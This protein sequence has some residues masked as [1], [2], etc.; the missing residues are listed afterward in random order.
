MSAYNI[1]EIS[2]LMQHIMPTIGSRKA[3][4]MANYR[5]LYNFAKECVIFYSTYNNL[6][7]SYYITLK[8]IPDFVRHEFASL[9]I[10]YDED[11]AREACSPDNELWETKMLPALLKY[12]K[13]TTDKDQEIEFTNIWRDCIAS[14]CEFK[15][16]ELIDEALCDYETSKRN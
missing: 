4:G 7:N 5:T 15:M 9:I 2:G 11:F 6:D 14:Y 8:D 1:H 3:H 10:A 16:Q 12:L 13:N